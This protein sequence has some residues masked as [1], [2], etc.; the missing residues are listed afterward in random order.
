MGQYTAER[1]EEKFA[2][3]RE[4]QLRKV[5]RETMRLNPLV[6]AKPAQPAP[7][8]PQ[9]LRVKQV[10]KILGVSVQTV[11]EWFRQSAVIVKSPRKSIMLIPQRTL[12]EW[13]RAHTAR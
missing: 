10:A 9:M 2:W 4:Q 6:I 13:V 5:D 1:R 8:T 3:M 12:D 7:A 11:R